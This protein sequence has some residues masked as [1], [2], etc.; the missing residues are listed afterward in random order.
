MN[1]KF[2]VKHSF[3]AVRGRCW[4]EV[5][6]VMLH[7]SRAHFAD[8]RKA[9]LESFQRISLQEGLSERGIDLVVK[10]CNVGELLNSSVDFGVTPIEASKPVVDGVQP[11]HLTTLELNLQKTL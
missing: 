8:A 6:P 4:S 9:V 5:A 7:N 11:E 2:S 10:N 3:D 1:A